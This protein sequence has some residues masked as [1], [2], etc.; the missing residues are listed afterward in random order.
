MNLLRQSLWRLLAINLAIGASAAIL[1]LGGLFVLNP[2][3][4]R[5]LILGDRT[6]AL[7]VGL[8]LF[9][10]LITFGSVAMGTAIMAIGRDDGDGGKAQFAP[11]RLGAAGSAFSKSP[12]RQAKRS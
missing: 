10:F 2:Y 8:L 4:L 1:M 7:A 11:V 12:P 6:P 3:E 5:T 9:G